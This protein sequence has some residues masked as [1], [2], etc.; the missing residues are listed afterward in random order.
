MARV[1]RV[2]WM[3]GGGLQRYVKLLYVPLV[4]GGDWGDPSKE[5]FLQNNLEINS[6]I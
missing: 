1:E 4:E 5:P 3:M 2:L 6:A